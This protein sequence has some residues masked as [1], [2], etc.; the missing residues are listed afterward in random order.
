MKYRQFAIGAGYHAT[1]A[2]G[3]YNPDFF[4]CIYSR[5]C[6]HITDYFIGQRGKDEGR[7]KMVDNQGSN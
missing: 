7:K 4:L 2:Q 1:H 5:L 6:W 3:S